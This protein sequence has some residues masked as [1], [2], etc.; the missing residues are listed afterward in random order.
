MQFLVNASP[1]ETHIISF[2]FAKIGDYSKPYCSQQHRDIIKR[3][4]NNIQ[5]YYFLLIK[6]NPTITS[7][8]PINFSRVTDSPKKKKPN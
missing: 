8:V 4:E 3:F 1:K 6:N 5:V 2:E 7:K